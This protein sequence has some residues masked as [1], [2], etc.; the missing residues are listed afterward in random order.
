MAP[1]YCAVTPGNLS[2]Q[3]DAVRVAARFVASSLNIRQDAAEAVI[4]TA[5]TEGLDQDP[6]EYHFAL[7]CLHIIYDRGECDI[8][9]RLAIDTSALNKRFLAP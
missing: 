4:S 1:F 5:I 8:K 7:G 9:V 2:F 6:L 3:A